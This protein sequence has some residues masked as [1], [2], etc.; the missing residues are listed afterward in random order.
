MEIILL[1]GYIWFFYLYFTTV[2]ENH[3]PTPPKLRK[4]RIVSAKLFELD[5]TGNVKPLI[6]NRE[7]EFFDLK[8][9]LEKTK[10]GI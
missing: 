8:K 4:T 10:N 9:D 1:I 3:Q 7:S 5:G 6:L 2:R